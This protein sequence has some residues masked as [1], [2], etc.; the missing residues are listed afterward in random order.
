MF[1]LN[2]VA[3]QMESPILP[4]PLCDKELENVVFSGSRSQ[5]HDINTLY[6]EADDDFACE[7]KPEVQ[8][9][10]WTS[11]DVLTNKVLC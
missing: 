11:S 8:I 5:M 9:L 3:L 7:L 10:H 2:F 6:A 1:L 4:S